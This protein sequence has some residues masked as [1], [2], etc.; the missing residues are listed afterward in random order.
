M[1]VGYRRMRP[2]F[3]PGNFRIEPHDSRF[4]ALYEGEELICVTVYK[5]GAVAV[6]DRLYRQQIFDEREIKK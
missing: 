6:M 5:A 4:Y 1:L 3:C 2:V